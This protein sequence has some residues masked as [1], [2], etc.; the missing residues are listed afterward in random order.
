METDTPMHTCLALW[1]S[2]EEKHPGFRSP[3]AFCRIPG[4]CAP[5]TPCISMKLRALPGPPASWEATLR[6][7]SARA[8]G[9]GSVGNMCWA[10]LGH[11]HAMCWTRVEHALDMWCRWTCL[12]MRW[13]CFGHVVPMC[14]TCVGHVLVMC[15]TCVGRVL[16]MS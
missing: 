8:D 1:S 5:Q 13:I 3:L 12:N 15:R 7:H 14:W 9:V 6:G 16:D 11:A 10:C 2:S 4:D